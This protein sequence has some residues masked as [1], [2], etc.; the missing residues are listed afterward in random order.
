MGNMYAFLD[1]IVLQA[2]LSYSNPIFGKVTYNIKNIISS[3]L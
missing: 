1:K 3:G 2:I